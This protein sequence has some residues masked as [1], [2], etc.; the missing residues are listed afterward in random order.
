MNLKNLQKEKLRLPP[1]LGWLLALGLSVYVTA[2]SIY[3]QPGSFMEDMAF[4]R[5]LPVLF[6]LNWWPHFAVLAALFCICQNVFFAAA[7]TSLVFHSLSLANTIKILG[8]DDPLVPADLG[9]AR[10]AFAAVREYQMAL[11]PRLFVL[12]FG[13]ILVFCLLGLLVKIRR[14]QAAARRPLIGWG[15]RV[16]AG[17]VFLGLFLLSFCKVY[18]DQ[19]YY[20]SLMV[21]TSSYY[22]ITTVYNELGFPY[23]FLVNYNK[24]PVVKPKGYSAREVKGWIREYTPDPEEEAVG[25]ATAESLRPHVIMVMNEAFT[26]LSQEA[27]FAYGPGEDPLEHFKALAAGENAVSGHLVV[28][29]FGAGTAN[30]EFDVLTGMQTA[31][32]SNHNTSAFRV[33]RSNL[34]ALPRILGRQGY[35]RLFL[36]PGNSWFYNRSSVYR[37]F[38]VE[39]QIFNNAFT[40]EDYKGNMISDAACLEKFLQAFEERTGPAAKDEPLFSYVVTIQNHQAYP[41]SKYQ[42][43]ELAETPLRVEVSPEAREQLTVYLEGVRDA[44]RMLGELAAY[45]EELPEPAVLVFFGDHRPALGADYLAYRELGLEWTKL[46][47]PQ[48]RIQANET[49]FLIWA[50]PAAA[51]SLDFEKRIQ[52]LDLPENGRIS[53]NFLSPVL[54]ELLGEQRDPFFNFL[55][56]LR[57]ELPVLLFQDYMTPQGE[58]T[59]SLTE[60][61]KEWEAVLRKWQYY[62]LREQNG[63]N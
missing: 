14:P 21:E 27:A 40:Q 1:W 17:L 56:R 61:Q 57:R 63:R 26:D 29:N 28:T 45:L 19:V 33:V 12:V 23:C 2:V 59:Q 30:T 4:F 11:D 51:G 9:L 54:A 47:T 60:E 32:I 10:E 5:E 49:P 35:Q 52:E 18:Q 38:G 22:H 15:L 3:V 43:L 16:A 50:N 36:H 53:A 41:Y 42:G 13:G 7:G 24:Y 34:E 55:N 48:H 46:A 62:R 8:R 25:N 58:F 20:E 44:D 39:D 31:L 6:L 37:Y